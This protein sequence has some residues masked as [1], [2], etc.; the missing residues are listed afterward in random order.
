MFI[1][2]AVR[3]VAMS[4]ANA[5]VS[6]P[7]QVQERFKQFLQDFDLPHLSGDGIRNDTGDGDN[8][9]TTAIE[10]TTQQRHTFDY[11]A[12]IASM[13]QNNRTTLF[14]NFQHI[15]DHDIEL[16]EGTHKYIC[17]CCFFFYYFILTR[18][19]KDK[20]IEATYITTNKLFFFFFY[21]N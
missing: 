12:Q 21:S 13:L 11:I 10:L 9:T 14:I 19:W 6:I 16:A 4:C 2:F 5:Y 18:S 15:V 7:L 1:S 8:E 20:D 17:S 3:I